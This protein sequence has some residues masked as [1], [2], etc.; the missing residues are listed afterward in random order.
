M[1]LGSIADELIQRTKIPLIIVHP[2]EDLAD[3]DR[4][5]FG[6]HIL[7]ALDGSALA[8][9]VLRP[10]S[11]LARATGAHMT[12]VRVVGPHVSAGEMSAL[13]GAGY[14]DISTA[15]ATRYL[16]E[17]AAAMRGE[18]L[19]VATRVATGTAPAPALAR[20]VNQ[21]DADLVAIATHGYGGIKRTALGSVAEQLLRSSSAPILVVHPS[22]AA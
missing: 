7:V 1:W 19:T 11:E 6:R 17:T 22:L 2:T 12:L 4:R 10:A 18:G 20:L 9:S 8:E 21:L 14:A 3:S 13:A 16:E 15:E 5:P